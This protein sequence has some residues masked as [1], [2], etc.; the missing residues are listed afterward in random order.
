MKCWGYLRR[1][2]KLGLS[3]SRTLL[4]GFRCLLFVPLFFCAVKMWEKSTRVICPWHFFVSKWHLQSEQWDKQMLWLNGA[5]SVL[6]CGDKEEWGRSVSGLCVLRQG[7]L[8]DKVYSARRDV[9][10]CYRIF[11]L[12]PG[13]CETVWSEVAYR[14]SKCGVYDGR[15]VSSCGGMWRDFLLRVSEHFA[16]TIYIVPAKISLAFRRSL[17]SGTSKQ[18]R[19]WRTRPY[20]D[21]FVIKHQWIDVLFGLHVIW[22]GSSLYEA[23]R[24]SVDNSVLLEDFVEC[25]PAICFFL[26]LFRWCSVKIWRECHWTCVSFVEIRAV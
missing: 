11:V 23:L 5:K 15:A 1:M 13:L 26:D 9:S 14:P 18:R 4:C 12:C 17:R 19:T 2:R 24:L 16:I 21:L 20:F 7:K 25:H 10:N 3:F 8:L 22:Y 6:F